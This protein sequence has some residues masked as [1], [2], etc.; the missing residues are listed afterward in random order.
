MNHSSKPVEPIQNP[1]DLVAIVNKK[2]LEELF[3]CTKAARLEKAKAVFGD[4]A[5][6]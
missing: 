4:T 1:K 2:P 5:V 3:A 6:I